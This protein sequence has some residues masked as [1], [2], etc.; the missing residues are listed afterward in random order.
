MNLYLLRHA[1][2][3]ERGTEGYE[4]DSMR[5]LT[6]K[7]EKKM[8]RIALGMKSLELAFDVILSSPYERAKRTADIVAE[9]FGMKVLFSDHL[10][11]GGDAKALIDTINRDHAG[12]ESILLVGHEPDLSSLASRLLAGDDHLAVTMKKGGLCKLSVETLR[13]GRCASLEFLL[14]PAQLTRIS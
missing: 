6:G 10:A 11:S 5:P 14:A 3:V 12:V 13:P 9:E 1:I 8:R 4:D 2:A 7:G